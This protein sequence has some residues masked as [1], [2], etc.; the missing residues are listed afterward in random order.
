M[1]PIIS[2][3]AKPKT[4]KDDQA[5]KQ[6]QVEHHWGIHRDPQWRSGGIAF[7]LPAD[8]FFRH[9]GGMREWRAITIRFSE[10]RL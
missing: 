6:I 8:V 3:G 1:R 9:S 5:G 2:A 4:R 10:S 7:N